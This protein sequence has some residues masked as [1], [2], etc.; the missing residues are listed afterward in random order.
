MYHSHIIHKLSYIQR[1]N[2]NVCIANWIVCAD[3]QARVISS[4]CNLC[5]LIQNQ[6]DIGAMILGLQSSDKDVLYGRSNEGIAAKQVRKVKAGD[7]LGCITCNL[8]NVICTGHC[9][10]H[11]I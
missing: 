10:Q 8:P 2:S 9:S 1:P 7:S 11:C 5:A 3:L 6:Q 4:V